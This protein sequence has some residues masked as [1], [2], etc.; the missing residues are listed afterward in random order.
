MK[1]GL[2]PNMSILAAGKRETLAGNM[3]L[4]NVGH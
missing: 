1:L 4:F 3:L 2:T